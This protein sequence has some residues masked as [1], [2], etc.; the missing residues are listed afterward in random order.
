M[1][2]EKEVEKAIKLIF[3]MYSDT[4]WDDTILDTTDALEKQYFE[5]IEPLIIKEKDKILFNT[6]SF[7]YLRKKV[8][9]DIYYNFNDTLN[10]LKKSTIDLLNILNAT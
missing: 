8:F 4:N 9:F 2:I 6:C 10:K 5:L 3:P 1:N 7:S